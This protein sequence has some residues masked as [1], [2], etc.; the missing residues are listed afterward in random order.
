MCIID[1]LKGSNN[2]PHNDAGRISPIS[3]QLETV[4]Y[5]SNRVLVKYYFSLRSWVLSKPSFD[6]CP[7]Y[8]V[9]YL[10]LSH[11]FV[12]SSPEDRQVSFVSKLSPYHLSQQSPT[13]WLKIGPEF[14]AHGKKSPIL[15]VSCCHYILTR[16]PEKV[17]RRTPVIL[18][19]EYLNM[20]K[21]VCNR[22]ACP[23][24]ESV[25]SM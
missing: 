10:R 11:P 20:T 16:G 3:S 19:A 12:L 14:P 25:P 5:T 6:C 8:S 7:E 17:L 24:L 21:G 2:V 13:L 22:H 1:D 23:T 18:P 9:E 15:S 4:K